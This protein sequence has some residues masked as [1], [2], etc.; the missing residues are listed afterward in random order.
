MLDDK[1]VLLKFKE[2]LYSCLE[3]LKATKAAF[4]ILAPDGKFYLKASYGFTK[5][6]VVP[7][8]HERT[9]PIVEALYIERKPF[10]F[11]S[12]AEAGD[13]KAYLLESNTTRILISPVYLERIAGFLDIRDKAAKEPFTDQDLMVADG[14]AL[15]FSAY[16]STFQTKKQI[17]QPISFNEVK[18]EEEVKVLETIYSKAY[19]IKT[20]PD[21]QIINPVQEPPQQFIN[22]LYKI[23]DLFLHLEDFAS[24]TINFYTIK[25]S[26]VISGGRFSLSEEIIQRINLEGKNLVLQKIKTEIGNGFYINK[27]FPLGEKIFEGK[28]FRGFQQIISL[29]QE[30][31]ILM[32]YFSTKPLGKEELQALSPFVTI[33]KAYLNTEMENFLVYKT[34]KA[35]LQ[36]FLQPGLDDY[37][38]LINHSLVVSEIAREFCKTLQLNPIEIERISLAGLLHDVGMRE[39]DYKNLYHK[40]KLQDDELRLLQQHPKIGAYLIQN[41][42]FPYEVYSLVLHHH[43]R[44]DGSGYPSQL[45]GEDIPLGARIIHIIEA[46][47]AMTSK[48]SYRPVIDPTH[49]LE[50][51]KS[52]AGI[53]FDPVL[54]PKFI[55]FIQTYDYGKATH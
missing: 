24:I 8:V 39:L 48:T 49:A 52:K 28:I 1:N 51:L 23:I 11:N 16:L 21:P 14:I 27:H 43:E 6:D 54:I 4:Y 19:A 26:Y 2:I 41:I 25:G 34:Y 10:Y 12:L 44:W 31:Q 42:P 29:K 55:S 35:L 37:S 36:K 53:Q 13:I 5:K 46:Y 40:K 22:S 32:N 47:D 30:Y 45:I 33:A 38:S 9:S 50:T 17:P 20:S 15:R 18:Q 7:E 3:E